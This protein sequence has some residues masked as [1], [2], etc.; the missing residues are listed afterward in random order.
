MAGRYSPPPLGPYQYHEVLSALRKEIKLN[1]LEAAIYWANV[2]LTFSEGKTGKRTL[3]KQLWIMSTEDIDDPA[4]V[5]R[6]FVVYQ[7]VDSVAETDQFLYLVAHMCRARKWWEHEEGVAV[8]TAWAKAIG[9]L[10]DPSRRREIPSYALDRHTRRGWQIFRSTGQFDDRFT[11]TDL[12]RQKTAYMFARDGFIDADSRVEAT[13]DGEPDGG[14]LKWWRKFRD[15][16]AVSRSELEPND[17]LG[18]DGTVT[19]EGQLFDIEEPVDFDEPEPERPVRRN[20][21]D[22]EEPPCEW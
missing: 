8:D 4:I 9:D 10:K 22:I 21:R 13:R 20:R 17:P 2:I 15:L 1:D 5:Q 14:F 3:A 19:P 12:G 11:G 6:A 7:M 16:M 18:P